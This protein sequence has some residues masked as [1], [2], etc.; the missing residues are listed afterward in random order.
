MNLFEFGAKTSYVQKIIDDLNGDIDEMNTMLSTFTEYVINLEFDG[1]IASLEYLTTV[2]HEM[3]KYLFII[4]DR[5]STL[6]D[7]IFVKVI[8]YQGESDSTIED[9]INSLKKELIRDYELK[10]KKCY[11]MIMDND[12]IEV[13]VI[14]GGDQD[15]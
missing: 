8:Q 4:K 13:K 1:D 12:N 3:D 7:P 15:E 14:D 10:Y 6:T 5:L 2:K 11:N 9:Y